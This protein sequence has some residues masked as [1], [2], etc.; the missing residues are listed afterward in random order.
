MYSLK[1]AHL[2]KEKTDAEVYNFYI[3]MRAFGKGYEEFYKR[4]LGEGVHF[5]RGKCAEVTDVAETPEE[6][7]KLIVVAEDTLLGLTRRLPVDMVIL[8]GALQP[9][10]RCGRGGQN[11]CGSIAH[12]ADSSSK[13]TPSWLRWT[14]SRTAFS[15]PVPVRDPRIFPIRWH[16]ALQPRPERL[17][18]IDKGKVVT[19]ADHGR[20]RRGPLRRLPAVYSQLPVRGHRVRRGKEDFGGYAKSCA[21]AAAP[22]WQVVRRA[23][24]IRE[25]LRTFRSSRKSRGLLAEAQI[26]ETE[27]AEQT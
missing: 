25:T 12:R 13:S 3:D 18:L 23:P 20:D 19:G 22:A 10:A 21:R 27:M 17:S 2:V 4:I 7:G 5:I 6:E 11:S 15:W 26:S 24:P 9:A 16:R 8:S 1:F 14:R